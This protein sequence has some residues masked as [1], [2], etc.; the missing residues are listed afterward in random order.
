MGKVRKIL[1][2]NTININFLNLKQQ[3][4]QRLQQLEGAFQV[5]RIQAEQEKITYL[6]HY[7]D[8]EAFGIFCN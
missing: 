3:T 6:L 8:I 1:G 4:F 7:I 5:F 2:Y